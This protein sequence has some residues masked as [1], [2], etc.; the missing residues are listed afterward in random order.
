MCSK[1]SLQESV[2]NNYYTN[3]IIIF[4][5]ILRKGGYQLILQE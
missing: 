1:H 4:K 5:I 2:L 3:N